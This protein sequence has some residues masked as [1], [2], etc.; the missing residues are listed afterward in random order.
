MI[1]R[2][3]NTAR[4]S[5]TII[6]YMTLKVDRRGV[7]LPLSTYEKRFVIFSQEKR[8]QQQSILLFRMAHRDHEPRCFYILMMNTVKH[9]EW[10]AVRLI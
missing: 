6:S 2:S 7:L 1:S 4:K 8:Q 5:S 9:Y 3:R 10:S